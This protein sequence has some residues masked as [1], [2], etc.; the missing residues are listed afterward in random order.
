MILIREKYQ[1][2]HFQILNLPGRDN[3]SSGVLQLLNRIECKID[4]KIKLNNW[5]MNSPKNEVLNNERRGCR[6]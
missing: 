6:I 3:F 2:K 1:K 5:K 4:R